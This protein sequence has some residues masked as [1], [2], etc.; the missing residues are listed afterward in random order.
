MSHHASPVGRVV[1]RAGS[2]A[3]TGAAAADALAS[4][5][6]DAAGDNSNANGD[7]ASN[8]TV[9]R[10]ATRLPDTLPSDAT[11][12][13]RVANYG[14][15]ALLSLCSLVSCFFTGHLLSVCF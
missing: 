13:M 2:L 8:A 7:V 5:D 12:A 1:G 10:S 14:Y 11:L 4:A 6:A 15:A 9:I 3:V